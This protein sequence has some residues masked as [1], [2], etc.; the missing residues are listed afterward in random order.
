MDVTTKNVRFAINKDLETMYRI[1]RASYLS[2]MKDGK[3]E[4]ILRSR[5]ALSIIVEIDT[6]V[7]GFLLYHVYQN[8]FIIDRMAVDEKHRRLGC[9]TVLL[10]NLKRKLGPLKKSI[11]VILP[12]SNLSAQLFLSSSGFK[13]E[14]GLKDYF[15][16]YHDSLPSVPYIEDGLVFRCVK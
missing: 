10:E 2:Y 3:I 5:N 1:D 13:V 4:N 8:K 15:T 14:K 7:A 11:D 12:E 9:G 6:E 16:T